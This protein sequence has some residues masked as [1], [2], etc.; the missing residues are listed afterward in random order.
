MSSSEGLARLCLQSLASLLPFGLIAPIGGVHFFALTFRLADLARQFD[1]DEVRLT[2]EVDQIVDDLAHFVLH[3]DHRWIADLSLPTR[4][5]LIAGR[6]EPIEKFA[7]RL[8]ADREELV[9][10]FLAIGAGEQSAETLALFE[11]GQEYLER[12]CRE[13]FPALRE[14]Q[15]GERFSFLA[16]GAE[17]GGEAIRQNG[18][19]M[20]ALALLANDHALRPTSP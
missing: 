18:A 14:M 2:V 13:R 15:L 7:G 8:F 9:S 1:A 3:A 20:R 12:S 17:I 10:P 5:F 6:R 16:R 19:A 11:F 4:L